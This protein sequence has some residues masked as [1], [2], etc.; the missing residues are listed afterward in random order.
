[1]RIQV[2]HSLVVALTNCLNKS[3]LC[4]S[5]SSGLNALAAII[6]ED[7]VKRIKPDA[8]VRFLFN[9][10]RA[11]CVVSGIL[12]FAFVFIARGMGDIFPVSYAVQWT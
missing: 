9:L 4:S 6:T 10:S 2:K 8:S 11:I 1:M 3:T 12:S 7:Y 5:V